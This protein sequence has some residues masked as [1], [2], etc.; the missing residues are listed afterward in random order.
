MIFFLLLIDLIY[1]QFSTSASNIMAI[2]NSTNTIKSLYRSGIADIGPFLEQSRYDECLKSLNE[3]DGSVKNAAPDGSINEEEYANFIKLY[4]FGYID[5]TFLG[6]KEI[7][8][9]FVSTYVSYSCNPTCDI[10]RED[11]NGEIIKIALYSF[12]ACCRGDISYIQLSSLGS[13]DFFQLCA[14][15]DQFIRG[16][17]NRMSAP[18]NKPSMILSQNPTAI[19]TT[20]PTF[21]PTP[22][23][24]YNPS[25]SIAPT[26]YGQT[27]IG[28][29]YVIKTNGYTSNMILNQKQN[30][31]AIYN[32]LINATTII[33]SSILSTNNP[34]PPLTRRTKRKL[35]EYRPSS[36]I[37]ITSVI[38][39]RCPNM[40]EGTN[41]ILI[42]SIVT[43]YCDKNNEDCYTVQRNVFTGLQTSFQNGCFFRFISS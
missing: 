27:K 9:A 8:L 15:T 43:I 19:P 2:S 36:P 14:Y 16:A 4:S 28:F 41:C 5:T 29:S 1:F 32:L 25:A 21:A 17:V 34:C 35:A 23:P 20:Y 24:S 31:D 13:S 6:L 40:E 38:D 42:N 18:S 26:P 11:E 10:G 12:S 30:V 37:E 7:S 3:A 22:S 39:I 33:S